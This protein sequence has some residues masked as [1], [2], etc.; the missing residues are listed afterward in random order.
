[1]DHNTMQ[2]DDSRPKDKAL[3]MSKTEFWGLIL[4]STAELGKGGTC[5][6]K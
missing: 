1:M 3:S 2:H 5:F 4:L 6:S